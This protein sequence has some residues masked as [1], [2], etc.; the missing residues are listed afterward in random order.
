M[1]DR[2]YLSLTMRQSDIE[3]LR[4]FTPWPDDTCAWWDEREDSEDGSAEI[5]VEE[6]NYAWTEELTNAAEKGR[7]A[8]YGQHGPGGDY[9]G[10]MFASNG[11]RYIEVET[12][13]NGGPVVE[14]GAGGKPTRSGLAALQTYLK[15]QRQ[16]SRR[17]HGKGNK[18]GKRG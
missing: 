1:A 3:A 11:R 4:E 18:N 7:I 12:S 2:C 16:A 10:G 5:T 14:Y 15:V 6:A 8:F 13:Y 9:G 17:V